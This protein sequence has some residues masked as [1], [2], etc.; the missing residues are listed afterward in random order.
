MTKEGKIV[1]LEG[2][3]ARLENRGNKNI[4]MPGVKKKVMRQLRNIKK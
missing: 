4:K 1:L 2:R 3:L